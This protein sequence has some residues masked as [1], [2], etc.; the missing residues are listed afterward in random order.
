V[1]VLD[2]PANGLDPEGR[3]WLRDTLLDFTRQGGTVLVSTHDLA[4]AELLAD[5]AII[6]SR[7]RV[8]AH[9]AIADLTAASCVQVTTSSA[10]QLVA[11]AS[12]LGYS[13]TMTGDA[14][15]IT[16]V[17]PEVVGRLILEY[18]LV[19]REMTAR[20]RTLEDVLLGATTP[21][22]TPEMLTD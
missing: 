12:R 6:L 16:H 19:I 13:A 5:E 21:Q 14:V 9:G 20:R 10:A 22:K 18:G 3:R 8:V 7:G 11:A 2:E 17:E 1:L 4:E 15:E